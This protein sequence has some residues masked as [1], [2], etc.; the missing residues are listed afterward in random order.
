MERFRPF[1]LKV[2]GPVLVLHDTG[3][4]IAEEK[5]TSISVN[6]IDGCPVLGLFGVE[7]CCLMYSR[8]SLW[9]AATNWKQDWLSGCGLNGT[10]RN[11]TG[12]N[13]GVA[14]GA[15]ELSGYRRR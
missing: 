5:T 8:Q 11:H 12:V 3:V 9:S 4:L 13:S 7:Y 1:A 14:R 2:N 15:R 6:D 10:R